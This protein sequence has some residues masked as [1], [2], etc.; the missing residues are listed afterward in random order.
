MLRTEKI[1]DSL[2]MLSDLGVNHID[3]KR[4]VLV[5]VVE[6]VDKKI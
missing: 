5:P 6:K 1:W 3:K 4:L 2:D